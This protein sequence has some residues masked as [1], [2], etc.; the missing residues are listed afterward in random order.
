[1]RR[2]LDTLLAGNHRAVG[3]GAASWL[4]FLPNC[5]GARPVAL[6]RL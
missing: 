3:Q 5:G 6:Q 4:G 2:V 1:M